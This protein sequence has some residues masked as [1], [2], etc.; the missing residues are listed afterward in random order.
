VLKLP[1]ATPNKTLEVDGSS[2]GRSLIIW[3]GLSSIGGILDDR[4]DLV[5]MMEF[6]CDIRARLSKVDRYEEAMMVPLP[7]DVKEF[8]FTPDGRDSD[9]SAKMFKS[10]LS[11]SRFR[12][13]ISF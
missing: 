11:A 4:I 2:G 7:D 10:N 8:R 9:R 1:C 13:E 12:V 6:R 3:R 5:E